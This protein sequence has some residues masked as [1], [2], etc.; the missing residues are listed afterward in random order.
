NV[1]HI[2]STLVGGHFFEKLLLSIEGA[3]SC[4]AKHFMA[5]EC[6]EVTINILHIYFQM[7]NC[8]SSIKKDYSSSFVCKFSH[9]FD[10]INRAKNIRKRS[11]RYKFHILF[12]K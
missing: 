8:L 11:N 12:K 1:D 7:R 3:N 9:L 10:R 5:R 2:P 4:R 6:K